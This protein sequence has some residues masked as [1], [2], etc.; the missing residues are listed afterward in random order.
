MESW[1]SAFV[2]LPRLK[3]KQIKDGEQLG[4]NARNN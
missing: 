1:I 4:I 3:P 2:F